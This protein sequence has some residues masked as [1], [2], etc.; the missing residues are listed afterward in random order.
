MDF[1]TSLPVG[2]FLRKIGSFRD[3]SERLWIAQE[4]SAWESGTKKERQSKFVTG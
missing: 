4:F 3:L 1:T 2:R